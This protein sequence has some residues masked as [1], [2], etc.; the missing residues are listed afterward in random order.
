MCSYNS[1][2]I[3]SIQ[4]QIVYNAQKCYFL[5][6]FN[7]MLSY[8]ISS[9]EHNTAISTIIS[10][11]PLLRALDPF[12]LILFQFLFNFV[13][14]LHIFIFGAKYF[15][16]TALLIRLLTLNTRMFFFILINFLGGKKT[17]VSEFILLSLFKQTE[18]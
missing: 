8:R 17:K 16:S 15:L 2:G 11:Y 5:E 1:F 3:R 18:F 12:C 14:H 4:Y 10:E 9:S 7:T 13:L 6:I